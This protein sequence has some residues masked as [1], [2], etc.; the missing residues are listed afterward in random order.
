MSHAIGKSKGR[1]SHMGF[2]HPERAIQ[3]LAIHPSMKV[4]DFGSGSGAYVLALARAVEKSG[5]V[6]AIDVQKDLLRRTHNEAQKHGLTNIEILWGDLEVPGGSKIADNSLEFVL[7]S[8]LLFQ[9]EVRNVVMHEAAR[10][11]RN[12]GRLAVIDWSDSFSGMGPPPESI[13]QKDEVLRL[14]QASQLSYVEEF[15]AGAHHFGLLFRKGVPQ[16]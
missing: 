16:E 9:M 11:L 7:I 3:S 5:K 10:V 15:S 14:A 8:N 4:A 13:V 1:I 12:G 6:F 2:A